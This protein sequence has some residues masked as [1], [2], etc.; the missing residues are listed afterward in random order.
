MRRSSRIFVSGLSILLVTASAA[1]AQNESHELDLRTNEIVLS[2]PNGRQVARWN[3]QW[4]VVTPDSTARRASLAV[5]RD[6]SGQ[7]LRWFSNEVSFLAPDQ[8][9]LFRSTAPCPVPPSLAVDRTGQLHVL[10]GTGNDVWYARVQKP[11]NAQTSQVRPAR[12][13]GK[14]SSSVAASTNDTA[15]YLRDT[16][17]WT[18]IGGQP[19]KPVLTNAS[20]GDLQVTETGEVWVLALKHGANGATTMCLGHLSG[21]WEFEDIADGVGFHPPAFDVLP[22]GTAHVAWSDTRGRL[23]YLRHRKGERAEP[24]VLSKGGYGSTGRNPS[25]LANGGQVIIANETQ[26]AEIEYAVLE[27]GKWRAAQRFSKA[28]RRLESDVMH[29][30]QLVMDNHGV[31]WLFVADSTRRFTYSARWLGKNWSDICDCRGIYYRAPRFETNFL[32][33]DWL[34]VEKHPPVE[35]TDIGVTL[36]NN[37][38]PDRTEFHRISVV[39]PTASSGSKVL[40][41]DMQEVAASEGVE[42]VLNEARKDPRNPVLK[43]G[44]PGSF[45]HERVLNHGTVLFDDNRFR[46]WYA[47]VNRRKNAYWWE[48]LNIGYAES[49]DG[50]LWN[51]VAT[52]VEGTS[53]GPDQNR[54]P[55]LPWPTA[56][57]KDVDDREPGRRYKAVQF[58]RHQLQLQ[59]SARGEYD[60]ADPVTPGRLLLSPDGIHWTTEPLSVEFP[61]GKLWELVVQSFF[62]DRN[63]L[64]PARRWKIYGYATVTARR[65]AGCFAY[66]ADGKKWISYPRN[67]VL[68]P[69]VS[70]VPLMPSGPLSQIHDTIVFPYAGYYLALFHAQHDQNFL[71]IELAVSRDGENFVHVKPGQKVIPLGEKGD[72]DWQQILQTTPVVAND[73]LWLFYGGQAPSP[74]NFAKGIFNNEAIRGAAGLATLRLDGFTCLALKSGQTSGHFTTVPFD[75][76]GGE[77]LGLVVNADCAADRSL[78]VEVLDVANGR[79]LAGFSRDDCEPLTSDDLKSAVRWKGDRRLPLAIDKRVA[80]RFWLSG[81]ETGPMVYGFQFVSL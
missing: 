5:F 66:S 30:P 42:L 56:V 80:F 33:P 47:G 63:E 17:S 61:D 6:L 48:W 77:P 18:G 37:L 32:A 68:D 25:I 20:T 76:R 57:F 44:E 23:L 38:A 29:S 31:V 36:A 15:T 70:E 55:L 3:G 65:R 62:I 19:P 26:H 13:T 79:P 52:G 59:A 27:D 40:F 4:L 28:D 35:S 2:R 75:A 78:Q 50:L 72:W 74:E 1:I 81:K 43:P 64:D 71:D 8:S 46:M 54:I 73:K 60:M 41:F 34:G 49:N 10:W 45:D 22:D 51:K 12:G 53:P 21:Q 16:K 39:K 7:S 11:Q 69:T 58:D 9:G 67:P 24:Q 14:G